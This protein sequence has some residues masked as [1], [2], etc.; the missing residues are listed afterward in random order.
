MK[1]LIQFLVVYVILFGLH[2]VAWS[3]DM[4][5]LEGADQPGLCYKPVKKCHMRELSAAEVDT[6][7]AMADEVAFQLM[8]LEQSE[9]K[10]RPRF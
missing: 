3:Q 9:K 2:T 5:M 4:D 6:A 1:S 8:Q 7:A 10:R